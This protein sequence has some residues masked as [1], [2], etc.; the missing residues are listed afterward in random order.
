M[1]GGM[2]GMRGR[3]LHDEERKGDCE[4]ERKREREKASC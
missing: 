2:R 4:R 1:K 3:D